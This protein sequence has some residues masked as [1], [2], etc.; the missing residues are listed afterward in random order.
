[1]KTMQEIKSRKGK[2]KTLEINQKWFTMNKM[3]VHGW[4]VN[5]TDNM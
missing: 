1:M 5:F 3:D 4:E 2:I